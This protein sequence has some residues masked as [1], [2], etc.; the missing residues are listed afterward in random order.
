MNIEDEKQIISAIENIDKCSSEEAIKTA[1][2]HT[3]EKTAFA[4]AVLLK[5]VKL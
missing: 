4:L 5:I 1:K 2:E 3:I